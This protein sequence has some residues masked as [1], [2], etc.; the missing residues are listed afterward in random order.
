MSQS[1][2]KNCTC[3]LQKSSNLRENM[4]CLTLFTIPWSGGLGRFFFATAEIQ[5]HSTTIGCY[6]RTPSRISICQKYPKMSSVVF[7]GPMPT[8]QKCLKRRC[9]SMCRHHFVPC[10]CAIFSP[11]NCFKGQNCNLDKAQIIPSIFGSGLSL[12]FCGDP[13]SWYMPRPSK[14]LRLRVA[15]KIMQDDASGKLHALHEDYI[16]F[17]SIPLH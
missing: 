4:V 5:E 12:S 3:L 13:S 14:S 17:P 6:S 7:R 2:H 8:T 9:P 15:C 11:N 10:S 1:G 16:I